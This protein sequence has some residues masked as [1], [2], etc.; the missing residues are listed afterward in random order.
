MHPA[1]CKRLGRRQKR[2]RRFYVPR[3]RN[4][5]RGSGV[6]QKI[7]REQNIGQVQQETEKLAVASHRGGC[8]IARANHDAARKAEPR[9][10]CMRMNVLALTM[11]AHRRSGLPAAKIWP[12]E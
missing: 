1:E 5:S 9:H 8:F 11:R 7:A 10:K 3:E 6:H 12:I 2:R 4:P